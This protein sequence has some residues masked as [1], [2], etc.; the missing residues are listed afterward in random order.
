MT[1]YYIPRQKVAC[2]CRLYSRHP[3]RGLA[4]EEEKQ[5]HRREQPMNSHENRGAGKTPSPTPRP[6]HAPGDQPEGGGEP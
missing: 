4:E 5:G 1:R 6:T 2:A 3:R